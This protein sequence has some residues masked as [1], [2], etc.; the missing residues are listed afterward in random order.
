[1]FRKLKFFA[2]A[3]RVLVTKRGCILVFIPQN[4]TLTFNQRKMSLEIKSFETSDIHQKSPQDYNNNDGE[5]DDAEG[6]VDAST[7][8]VPEHERFSAVIKI[9][10]FEECPESGIQSV[11]CNAAYFKEL[12]IVKHGYDIN[13]TLYDTWKEDH[14]LMMEKGISVYWHNE[15]DTNKTHT[16]AV[17][18]I[19]PDH[20]VL[21]GAMT[22]LHEDMVQAAKDAPSR[23]HFALTGIT[24]IRL[25]ER[26][27]RD[28][29]Q[30][31]QSLS[32]GFL[33]VVMMLDWLRSLC[34]PP[35]FPF[36]WNIFKYHKT[37]DL[38][39]VTVRTTYPRRAQLAPEAWS[40][41]I[42][43]NGQSRA[44]SVG[45]AVMC[46][47][48]NKD[49]GI[50]F[51]LRTIKTHNHLGF[52]LWVLGFSL[53]YWLFA[54]PWWNTLVL[55]WGWSILY[56]LTH[57]PRTW[58]WLTVYVLHTLIVAVVAWNNMEL[59][60]GLLPIQVLLY[61][62]YLTISPIVLVYGRFHMS[63]ASWKHF[64]YR[65]TGVNKKRKRKRK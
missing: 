58:Y 65:I 34:Q 33:L 11:L 13:Q 59:P 29:Y 39:A 54:W 32:Y 8:K 12:H 62:F 52:G 35:F 61:T 14:N 60:L 42:W 16:H 57:D 3:Q 4:K 48:K 19:L 9:S 26:Q 38:R 63:R 7:L 64:K 46:I 22:T 41:W 44:K 23:T 50:P 28:V 40:W 6:A 20:Q 15:F 25:S 55:D 21:S 49:V 31:M 43:N 56:P 47:P 45:A 53:Y 18:H 1:M 51:V 2:S 5:L 36:I 37:S 30:W 10:Q 17:V 24:S 27:K